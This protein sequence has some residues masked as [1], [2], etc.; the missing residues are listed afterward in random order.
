MARLL[1]AVLWTGLIAIAMLV[2]ADPQQSLAWYRELYPGDP[3]RRAALETCFERDH[4]FNR[5]DGAARAE[6][7]RREIAAP[8]AVAAPAPPASSDFVDRWRAAGRG[9][10][11]A[12]DIGRRQAEDR[13]LHPGRR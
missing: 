2:A 7:Y 9:R 6:C 1:H 10:Q 4:G 8:P 12:D 11:P 13:Y 5:A 3:A